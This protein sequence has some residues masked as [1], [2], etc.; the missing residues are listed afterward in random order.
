MV[1]ERDQ[2]R[3]IRFEPEVFI[4]S[5][6]CMSRSSTNGPFLE[7]LLMVSPQHAAEAEGRSLR[8]FV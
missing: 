1:E 6:L 7:D 2:V 3:I 5:I 4:S 8:G